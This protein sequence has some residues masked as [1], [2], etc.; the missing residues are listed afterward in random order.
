MRRKRYFEKLEA[1]ENEMRFLKNREMTDDV[2]RRAIL[3][4]LQVC[5]DVATDVVAMVTRDL[6]LVVED[7]YTNI[8]KLETEGVLRKGEVELIRSFNG[9]R[10][11]IV[12]KY[13]HLDLAAVQKGLQKTGELY[14]VL[15]KLV[16]VAEKR[17]SLSEEEKH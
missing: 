7:D 14:E 17:T 2:T 6:G 15:V 16:S 11:A 8:E 9:L 1:F 13:N 4:A 5:V 10:N 12:H 3:Y